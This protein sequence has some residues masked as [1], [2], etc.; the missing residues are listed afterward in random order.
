[1][2]I[3]EDSKDRTKAA[4]GTTEFLDNEVNRTRMQLTNKEEEISLFKSQHVGQ[5]PQ[6]IEANLRALDR[7]HDDLNAVNESIHRQTDRLALVE[8]AH[9]A[10]S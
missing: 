3:D 6:Q 5:L 1:M 8:N 2:L 10:I 7:L 9:S 4:E